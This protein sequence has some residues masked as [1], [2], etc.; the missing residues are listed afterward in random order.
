MC[1]VHFLR[2]R[3]NTHG[4]HDRNLVALDP[5]CCFVLTLLFTG[6]DERAQQ[7]TE[8]EEEKKRKRKRKSNLNK[9]NNQ[10]SDAIFC[11]VF[12]LFGCSECCANLSDLYCP[13]AIHV[14]LVGVIRWLRGHSI[15]IV[16]ESVLLFV[17]VSLLFI[18]SVE[19][20]WY[21][22]EF[23]FVLFRFFSFFF[24]RSM[25]FSSS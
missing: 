13:G 17:H 1:H 11:S 2:N 7:A 9:T 22:R 23:C 4:V 14:R 18:L 3:R 25:L 12:L 19:S 6:L 24:I 15:W 8:G 16:S 10:K 21:R 5:N 20:Y